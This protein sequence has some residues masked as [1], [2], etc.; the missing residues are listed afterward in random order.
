M[1]KLVVDRV[2]IEVINIQQLFGWALMLYTSKKVYRSD[3]IIWMGT[4][5]GNFEMQI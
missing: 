4:E 1:L 3:L 5:L 2:Q